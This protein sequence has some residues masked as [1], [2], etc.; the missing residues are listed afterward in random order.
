MN[1]IYEWM[2]VI[3][4]Y[5]IISVIIL[6]MV[7]NEKSRKFISVFAG[8]IMILMIIEPIAKIFDAADYFEYSLVENLFSREYKEMDFMD[9]DAVNIRKQAILEEYTEIIRENISGFVGEQGLVTDSVKVDYEIGEEGDSVAISKIYVT[10]SRK[11]DRDEAVR[12]AYESVHGSAA[13]VEEINIKKSISNFY[14]IS[15]DNII[16]EEQ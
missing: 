9:S 16:Y 5:R 15:T 14:K 4:A 10:V 7:P 12:D 11:Y 8:L 1:H 6:E 2:K 13:S 3:L